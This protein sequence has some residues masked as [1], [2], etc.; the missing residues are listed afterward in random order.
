MLSY[1]FLFN[2]LLCDVGLEVPIFMCT[3]CG[4][5][6]KG[7]YEICCTHSA[8]CKGEKPPECCGQPMIEAID[9]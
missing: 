9:D 3:K 2:L 8:V 5:K 6:I 7:D 1:L 4:R